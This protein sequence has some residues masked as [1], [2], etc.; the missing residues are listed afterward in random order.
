V[1]ALEVA[2]HPSIL[3]LL[4][5]GAHPG[6]LVRLSPHKDWITSAGI[7]TVVDVGGHTGQFA[8]AIRA[9]LPH[10][11]IFSFEPLPDCLDRLTRRL[12][13]RGNFRGFGVAL[14]DRAGPGNLWRSSFSESSSMLPMADLHRDAF[15]W[16]A[17][18]VPEAVRMETLDSFLTELDLQPGVLLKLDVQGF[19]E[20]VLLGALRTLQEVQ[21]VLV[22]VSFQPLY[23]GQASFH[24]VYGLLRSRGFG[25]AGSLGQLHSPRDGSILQADALFARLT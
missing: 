20:K 1:Y 17:R 8:S 13:K 3:P 7:R 24:D 16:S 11:Q 15:P 12:S 6:E 9:L 10:A 18:T 25:Y 14:G 23:V 19:E 5:R 22:E 4:F 21:Y 2:Q